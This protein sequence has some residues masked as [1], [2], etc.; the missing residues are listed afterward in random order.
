MRV[1]IGANAVIREGI[2]IG[3]EAIIGAGSVVVKDVP[4]KMIVAG[5]PSKRIK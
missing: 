1:F 5:N 4:P 3:N 2:S